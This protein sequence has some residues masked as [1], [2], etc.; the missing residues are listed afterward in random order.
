MLTVANL[1]SNRYGYD[2]AQGGLTDTAFTYLSDE[3]SVFQSTEKVRFSWAVD[4]DAIG[5]E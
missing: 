3:F 4:L 2:G 5:V 1:G